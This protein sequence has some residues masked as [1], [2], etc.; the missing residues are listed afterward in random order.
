SGTVIMTSL[1]S[2]TPV[3]FLVS[4]SRLQPL[5]PLSLPPFPLSLPP[6]PL[7]L[8]PLPLSLPLFP[9]FLPFGGRCSPKIR[10]DE[11][12]DDSPADPFVTILLPVF[13]GRVAELTAANAPPISATSASAVIR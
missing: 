4:F 2:L 11:C 13:D 12:D 9:P 5:S 8:P 3:I 7:S 6:F 10:F 1:C